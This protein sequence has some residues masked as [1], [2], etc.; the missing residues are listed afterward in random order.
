MRELDNQRGIAR[1]LWQLGQCAVRPGNYRQ[2]VGYFEAALPLLRQ[3]GDRSDTT[4]ALSGLAEVAIRQGN[5]ERASDLEEE[6]LALRRE[7]GDKW[8][9]A[10]SFG[11]MAWMAMR[12]N[13]VGEA[14]SFLAESLL[15]RQEIGDLGGAA[16]CI[17]TRSRLRAG[18]IPVCYSRASSD[19]NLRA[20]Q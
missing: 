4:I 5:L 15:L 14:A 18:C 6:S 9:I 20:G 16:R 11:N 12:R 7:L 8:G 3:Q 19:C 2:A 17:N 1:A 13:R 10:V